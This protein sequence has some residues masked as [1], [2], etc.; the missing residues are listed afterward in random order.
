MFLK[1]EPR[2]AETG[3]GRIRQVR[4]FC[5]SFFALADT[6]RKWY[7]WCSDYRSRC[8]RIV[9]RTGTVTISGE[10]LRTWKRRGCLLRNFQGKQRDRPCGIRCRAGKSDGKAECSGKQDDGITFKRTRFLICTN[11]F[12]CSLYWGGK[13]SEIGSASEERDQKWRRKSADPRERRSACDGTESFRGY[14]CGT[15]CADSGDRLSVRSEHRD[16]RK[17]GSERRLFLFRYES[18]NNWTDEIGWTSRNFWTVG[19][20]KSGIS[21]QDIQRDIWSEIYRKCGGGLCR[22]FPQYGQQEKTL[23]YTEKRGVLSYG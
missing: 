20:W 17:C 2:R 5:R 15:L 4:F 12:V 13:Y 1:A 11:R 6:R 23:Y 18:G 16:G 21:D 19:K 22:C 9:D 14:G 7:V 8:V 10:C 3:R